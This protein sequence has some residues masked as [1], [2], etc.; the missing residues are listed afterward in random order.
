[1]DVLGGQYR[2]IL[3]SEQQ[4]V[5]IMIFGQKMLFDNRGAGWELSTIQSVSA[6]QLL[7]RALSN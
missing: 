3:P 5:I 2:M 4:C 6:T 7:S 1:M